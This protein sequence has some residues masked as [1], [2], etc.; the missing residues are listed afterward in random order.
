MPTT[1]TEN[2]PLLTRG[3]RPDRVAY[4]IG[5]LLGAEDFAAEQGYHRGRLA[6]ALAYLHGTGTVAG[7][8]VESEAPDPDDPRPED[9]ERIRIRPGMAL[10][11]EG[12]II[13]VPTTYCTR[14]NRWLASVSP[15]ERTRG[16]IARAA[17]IAAGMVSEAAAP[18]NGLFAVDV[19]V[20]FVECERGKTP[21]FAT[22]PFDALDAVAPSRL[23]DGFEASLVLRQEG[24]PPPF[25]PDPWGTLAGTTPAARRTEMAEK[26]LNGW[27]E[28]TDSFDERGRRTHLGGYAQGQERNEVFLARLLVPARLS[29]AEHVRDTQGTL[30][31]DNSRRLFV[32]AA[33]ALA[34]I[35]AG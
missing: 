10:D 9:G 6:R 24:P 20:R 4:A 23:R 29:G 35:I 34:R 12:R 13:E 17:A 26:I 2:D 11:P 14:L 7:L 21:A 18:P 28:G 30:A 19:F 8:R 5:A 32:Y 27:H 22:G 31:V 3:L 25:P 33:G 1:I 15:A 16:F